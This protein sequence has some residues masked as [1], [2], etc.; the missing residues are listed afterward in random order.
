MH[1]MNTQTPLLRPAALLATATLFA[2]A[3]LAAGHVD[4]KV[5]GHWH[6]NVSDDQIGPGQM[7]I[8]FRPNGTATMN[9]DAPSDKLVAK[10]IYSTQADTLTMVYVNCTDNGQPNPVDKQVLKYKI[11]ETKLTIDDGTKGGRFVLHR[12]KN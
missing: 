9:V 2:S 8:I 1:P 3:A 10:V 11:T 12:V 4:P 6:G 5:V 7:D